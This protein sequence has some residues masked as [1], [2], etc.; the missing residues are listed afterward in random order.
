VNAGF[1]FNLNPQTFV[2]TQVPSIVFGGLDPFFIHAVRTE[3]F[4]LG[5]ALNDENVIKQ[6][7]Q[8]LYNEIVPNKDPV[9][10]SADYQ[11][12]LAVSLFYK[13]LL[14]VNASTI[15]PANASGLSSVID[16]RQVSSGTQSFP[17]NPSTYP[18]SKPMT[19]LN[20]VLQASGEAKY[21]FDKMSLKNQL[22]G[23]FITSAQGA[24][25]LDKIDTTDALKMPG[26]VKILFARDIMGKNSFVAPPLQPE[27]LFA[28]DSVDY[29]GQAI[30][31]VVAKSFEQA[32]EAA[33]AVKV[34]YK[35]V[36]KPILTIADAI[37]ANSL[38]PKPAPDFVYGN[39]EQAIANAD[40]VVD[41]DCFLDTQFHFYM[42]QQ[43]AVA[44]PTDDGFD[45][46]SST[47]Y[48]DMVQ[49]GVAYVLGLSNSGSLNVRVTQLGGAYG[50][51]ITRSNI[52]ATAAALAAKIL[53][54]PVRVS[55]DMNTSM[56]LIGKRFPWYAL[57]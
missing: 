27:K 46:H 3:A 4:L 53:N 45:I 28:D 33:K 51:K 13:F 16:D 32:R 25:R 17:T 54:K 38:Y 24:C 42:E 47:Q 10:S 21:T 44:E 18:V 29:A 5:K 31:L 12:S 52:P 6:A 2:V 1:R 36:K 40:H 37:K 14:H 35:E 20:A 34:T 41:G 39:A 48:L 22:E 26:V 15:S 43:N 9:F 30:G 23:A 11:R 49:N 19:K 7:F 56:S 50:G 57:I 8:V 55:I